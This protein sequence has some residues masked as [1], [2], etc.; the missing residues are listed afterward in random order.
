MA[1]IH[2]SL[3]RPVLFAGVEPV[4][5][6]TEGAAVLGLLVVVGLHVTT[7]ALAAMYI[8]VVHVLL[9]RATASDP[10][11]TAVYLRSLRYQDYYPP[12]AYAR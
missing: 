10:E 11:I 2:A 6:I 5:A 4:V 9:V 12:H 1:L 8:G 3:H 7:I